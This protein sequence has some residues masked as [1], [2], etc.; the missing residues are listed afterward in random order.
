M[1][2]VK[3]IKIV[4]DIFDNEK[5]MLIE[6]LP[7]ADTIIVLW[8]KLLCLAGKQNNDGV[9]TLN[10]R[11]PYTEEM[12]SAI[13]RRPTAT[14]KLALQTFQNFGMIEIVNNVVTIPNWNKH[15]TLDSYEKKKERDRIYRAERRANQRALI[16]QSSDSRPT[17]AKKSSCVV[18]SDIEEDIER[19]IDI[20]S[21]GGYGG[22]MAQAPTPSGDKKETLHKYGSYGWVRLTADQYAK[23]VSDL[24]QAELD[25]CIGYIDESAQSSGNKNRWKDWNLVVRRCSREKWGMR[26]QKE[27]EQKPNSPTSY[28]LEEF[29]RQTQFSVPKF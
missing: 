14:V 17:V 21:I 7:E 29:K 19:D 16:T 15:Q 22:S 5:I 11:I 8:F 27:P 10:D 12:F 28:D 9:F 4:T 1:A 26:G 24:G 18:V 23:L 13:F 20:E 25:R 2:D 3:W 6:S